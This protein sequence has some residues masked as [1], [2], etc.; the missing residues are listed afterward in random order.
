M[1]ADDIRP[2]AS[3]NGGHSRVIAFPLDGSGAFLRGEPVIIDAGGQ[4]NEAANDPV[5]T[6]EGAGSIGIA[7]VGAQE[8]ADLNGTNIA[9]AA[10]EPV[11]V[12][13][14]DTDTEYYTR[15]LYNSGAGATYT[16]A[17]I[18]DEC[19]LEVVGGVWGVD[20]TPANFNFVITGLLDD[21]GKDAIRNSTTVSG[22]KFRLL[23][24]TH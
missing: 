21:D 12:Y 9:G 5:L 10:N 23:N 18:G 7:A 22:A 19:N 3:S 11:G 4:V 1:A 20:T 14:F 6:A 2:Y 8:V 16:V 17:N 15:N 24:S 13:V